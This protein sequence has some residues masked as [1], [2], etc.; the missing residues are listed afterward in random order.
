MELSRYDEAESLLLLA[1]P[2]LESVLGTGA[3]S[4]QVTRRR[5]IE[6]YEIL[7]RPAEV[8][9]FREGLVDSS[10]E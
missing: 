5:I 6:L 3:G 4:E 2:V 8:A 9:R 7:D 1:H 10:D